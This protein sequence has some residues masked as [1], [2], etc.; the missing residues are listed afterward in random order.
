MTRRGTNR[1]RGETEH[2]EWRNPVR[3][4]TE[5]DA[6]RIVT[7]ETENDALRQRVAKLEAQLAARPTAMREPT[8]DE[9][10]EAMR[11]VVG[12]TMAVGSGG[13]EPAQ[14]KAADAKARRTKAASD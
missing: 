12:A 14:P 8:S 13:V 9:I 1:I 2:P 11:R 10:V 7:L 6:N 4:V 5:S 3:T